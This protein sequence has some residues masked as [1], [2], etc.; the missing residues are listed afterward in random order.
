MTHIFVWTMVTEVCYFISF[1]VE[2]I[3]FLHATKISH[4][5]WVR[6]SL[7]IFQLIVVIW[8]F[9]V[10]GF[11]PTITKEKFPLAFN[12]DGNTVLKLIELKKNIQCMLLFRTCYFL[13]IVTMYFA[14]W[15]YLSLVY[16][17]YRDIIVFQTVNERL[18]KIPILR[19]YIDS[20]SKAY[21]PEN[22]D[23]DMCPICLVNFIPSESEN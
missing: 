14:Y 22:H 16:C 21:N 9:M 11:T 12:I 13:A 10:V 5:K 4:I 2:I 6:F 15:C 8:G 20:E 19:Q 7:D 3:T 17:F 18:D 23:S 1:T